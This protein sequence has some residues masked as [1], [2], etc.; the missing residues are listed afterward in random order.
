VCQENS[1]QQKELRLTRLR[2]K[3]LCL[4]S[5]PTK[6]I[7]M[8][9]TMDLYRLME[10]MMRDSYC[11]CCCAAMPRPSHLE[12]LVESIVMEPEM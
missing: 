9:L 3:K 2:F 4:T 1:H 7:R 12:P 6:S 8:N 11:I 10:N 5:R